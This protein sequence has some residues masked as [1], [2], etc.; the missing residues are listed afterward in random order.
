[1][2]RGAGPWRAA[3][4][5]LVGQRQL[6]PGAG[7]TESRACCVSRPPDWAPDMVRPSWNSF[8]DSAFR[9]RPQ[10][11]WGEREIQGGIPAPGTYSEGRGG[12]Y[13]WKGALHP[14]DPRLAIRRE[15]RSAE[16]DQELRCIVQSGSQPCDKLRVSVP[17]KAFVDVL[18]PGFDDETGPRAQNEAL[19]SKSDQIQLRSQL[20]SSQVNGSQDKWDR[21]RR[22]T[23]GRR[24][25]YFVARERCGSSSTG[26][27]RTRVP[28]RTD[29]SDPEPAPEFLRPPGSCHELLIRWSHRSDLN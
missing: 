4:L 13:G 26:S 23:S 29:T 8:P 10:G 11:V 9:R 28:E 25:D 19:C 17:H 6:A 7:G 21:V 1:M 27:R 15:D 5:P 3:A 12:G 20:Q 24:P 2:G 18:P 22:P 14:A 16:A